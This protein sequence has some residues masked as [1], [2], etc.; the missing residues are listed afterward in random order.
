MSASG[1]LSLLSLSSWTRSPTSLLTSIAGIAGQ[2]KSTLSGAV[3]TPPRTAFVYDVQPPSHLSVQQ[4][5]VQEALMRGTPRQVCVAR[6]TSAAAICHLQLSASVS[7]VSTSAV[8]RAQLCLACA[9][10]GDPDGMVV[11]DLVSGLGRVDQFNVVCIILTIAMGY[12]HIHLGAQGIGH[13]AVSVSDPLMRPRSLLVSAP[14][15]NGV[16]LGCV[17]RV[18]VLSQGYTVYRGSGRG[19]PGYV[20]EVCR[21]EGRECGGSGLGP[22]DL[23]LDMTD[24]TPVAVM[25]AEG[26][27]EGDGTY[28]LHSESESDNEGEG[29]GEREREGD[30]VV[31]S[32]PGQRVPGAP[33]GFTPKGEGDTDKAAQVE[34]HYPFSPLSQSSTLS[35]CVALSALSLSHHDTVQRHCR[36][37]RLQ[38]EAVHEPSPS[39][40]QTKGERAGTLSA[41]AGGKE[42]LEMDTDTHPFKVES[43]APGGGVGGVVQRMMPALTPCVDVPEAEESLTLLP[44]TRTDSQGE[45]EGE[46]EG[47]EGRWLGESDYVSDS[48]SEEDPLSVLPWIAAR[49]IS[50]CRPSA[51]SRTVC[52]AKGQYATLF[53]GQ[54]TLLRGVVWMV[55]ALLG[56]YLASPLSGP[57]PTLVSMLMG[58][59]WVAYVAAPSAW[60]VQSIRHGVYPLRMHVAAVLSLYLPVISLFSGVAGVM[61]QGDSILGSSVYHAA[62]CTLGTLLALCTPSPILV[63]MCALGVLG[64]HTVTEA[65]TVPPL[66][67]SVSVCVAGVGALVRAPRRHRRRG[68]V[69]F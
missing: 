43:G 50:R 67:L 54:G 62:C 49:D 19:L 3:I 15:L 32:D 52:L 55:C 26:E 60:T 29:E 46:G 48:E 1:L 23:L 56:V 4:L 9:V 64:V 22:L 41:E 61:A 30:G 31:E 5:L 59:M 10:V 14:S 69:M 47:E 16:C 38:H 24:V 36:E 37:A 68:V 44:P 45:T 35:R 57:G 17:P 13:E 66:P 65:T 40:T 42:A 39:Q 27:G 33:E 18:V 58:W 25:E 28:D 63:V 6:A 7:S 51:V 12:S 21:Q 2:P 34:I 8:G 20:A 53:H 11:G